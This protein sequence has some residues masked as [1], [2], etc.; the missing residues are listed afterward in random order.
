MKESEENNR[1]DDLVTAY[2][3][4]E[5][6]DVD[7][8]ALLA[9]ARR[10]RRRTAIRHWAVLSLATAAMLT[11]SVVGFILA[12]K[13]RQ[14]PTVGNGVAQPVQTPEHNPVSGLDT[15]YS[16]TRSSLADVVQ[17]MRAALPQQSTPDLSGI[18]G[19][20]AESLAADANYVRGKV[21]ALFS[22]SVR[23]AGLLM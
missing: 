19:R 23:K 18:V 21:S 11:V 1:I 17:E 2:L 9:R 8:L 10:T 6:S 12:S 20:T 22:E 15:V 13:P 7:G 14:V 16:A 5:A 4:A 3:E